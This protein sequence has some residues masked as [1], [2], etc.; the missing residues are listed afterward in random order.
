M[1]E[2]YKRPLGE[3]FVAEG[4][5]TPEQLEEALSEQKRSFEK[6]GKTLIDMAIVSEEAVTEAR[7]KQLDVPY[8]NLQEHKFEPEILGLIP[9]SLARRCALIPIRKSG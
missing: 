3:I 7:A 6:L 4:V 9:E 5:I 8:V 2:M 1:S